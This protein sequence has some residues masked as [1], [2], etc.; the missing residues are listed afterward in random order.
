LKAQS[1]L[2]F[3]NSEEVGFLGLLDPVIADNYY[4]IKDPIYICEINLDKIFE[5]KKEIKREFRKVD[6]PAIKREYSMIVPLNIEFKEIQ[7]IIINVADI[8]E[9][10]KIFDVYRGK[11]IEEDKTSITVSI[12]YRSENKTLTEE[13]VNQVER[14]ILESLN[15]KGIK[16]RES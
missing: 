5:G 16:L 3:I 11:N 15:N 9:D 8:V 12:V 4:E 14:S 1:A 7:E 10:F 13:E 6:F 2:L